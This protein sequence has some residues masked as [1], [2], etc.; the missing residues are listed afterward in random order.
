MR[1]DESKI[2][3]VWKT[4]SGTQD[5]Y[6]VSSLGKVRSIDRTIIYTDGRI[7]TYPQRE[8]KQTID[9]YG[10]PR[11]TIRNHSHHKTFKVHRLVAQAFIENPNNLKEVNHINGDKKDNRV[12]NLEWVSSSQNK[13]H[14]V[15]MGLSHPALNARQIKGANN[16]LSKILIAYKDGVEIKRW[17]PIYEAIK[18][19]IRLGPLF[20][21]MSLG[22]LYKGMSFKKIE[23]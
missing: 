4:I 3:E 21:Q 23:K 10:Y 20:H 11:I 13:L 15:R 9:A 2:Q 8:L 7:F 16:R 18:D 14:A 17:C 12:C 1:H 22:R 6:E 19:G 5:R